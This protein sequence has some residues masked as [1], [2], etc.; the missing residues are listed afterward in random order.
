MK[1]I[2][3]LNE[4]CLKSNST[5]RELNSAHQ[6]LK[7]ASL[8][9]NITQINFQTTEKEGALNKAPSNFINLHLQLLLIVQSILQ[10]SYPFQFGW[11]RLFR[12]IL[13]FFHD[14][15]IRQVV[16]FLF[17]FQVKRVLIPRLNFL[18]LQCD[19]FSYGVH[20]VVVSI[21]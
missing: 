20:F 6:E 1:L 12:L 3:E 5:C 11:L 7:N 16:P 14:L 4:V 15:H 17:H 19:V 18:V 21:V 13:M 8:T 2:P 10:Y 9:Q